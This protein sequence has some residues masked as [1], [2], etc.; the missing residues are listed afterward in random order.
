MTYTIIIVIAT[1][2]ISIAGFSNPDIIYKLILWPARMDEPT[3]YYR[4]L[5]SGFI[6]ADWNHLLFNMYA[7]FS[8]GNVVESTGIGEK[9]VV[10]YLTGIIIAS[11]PSF[12]RH[13]HD[14]YYRSL[15]A[16]GGVASLI[17]FTIYFEPW[18]RIGFIFVPIG[19]P[20]I[21]F[22]VLYLGFEAYMDRRGNSRYNHNAHFWGSV[23]GLIFALFVDP[24][25][26]RMFLEALM[27]PH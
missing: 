9:Y 11:L 3:Q 12:W 27:D 14:D 20:S 17:F 21:I 26:G 13:R 15:G 5:S 7:L 8:F 10:L 1:V 18:S 25:H 16:S 2:L 24:T 23:Y 22:G 6:H 19:I 4:L